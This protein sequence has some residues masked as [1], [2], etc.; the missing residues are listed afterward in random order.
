MFT[1]LR[2]QKI[3][4]VVLVTMLLLG[5]LMPGGL[6]SA[7]AADGG[8]TVSSPVYNEDGTVTVNTYSTKSEMYINGNFTDWATFKPMSLSGTTTVDG[9][10]QNVF[11]YN[12]STQD[13]NKTGGVVQYKYIPQASWS[14]DYVDFLNAGPK[15]GGNSAVHFLKLGLSQKQLQPGQSAK[16]EA[17]RYLADGNQ[18]D[19]TADV[20]WTSSQPDAVTFANGTVQVAPDAP[21]GTLTLTGV[22]QGV[23]ATTALEIVEALAVPKVK[24]VANLTDLNDRLMIGQATPEITGEVEIEDIT[25]GAGKG[26][27]L[28]A[29]LG[30]RFE[31]D[32]DYTWTQAVYKDD[33]GNS[34]RFSAQFTPDRAGKWYY[35]MRFSADNGQTWDPKLLGYKVNKFFDEQTIV[36]PY[37]VVLTWT[38]DAK[39]TQTITWKTAA[40]V[41][42]SYVQYAEKS[43]E[44]SFPGVNTT[45][46][47]EEQGFSAPQ[48]A[49]VSAKFNT[50][51]L[52]GLKPGTAYVYRVGAGTEWS[53][54]A[55]FTTEASTA[56]PF[57]FLIFGDSQSG[58]QEESD[59]AKWGETVNA[60]YLAN[61]EAKFI[62]NNGDLVE[63][64]SDEHWHKWF[65]GAEGVIENIPEM[66]VAGNHEY[67][68]T[69]G[70]NEQAVHFKQQ[71]NL[72]QNGPDRLKGLVYSYNYGDVHIAVLNSQNTEANTDQTEKMGDI[73]AEQAAWLDQ[74]LKNNDKKWTIVFY[75]KAS[76]YSRAGRAAD[77]EQVKLAFQPIIDK[78]HVDLV[79]GAHDHTI[80]RTFPIYNNNF[81][82]NTAKGTVYYITGRSGNKNYSDPFQQVWD[83]YYKND[84]EDTN[85]LSVHV[86]GD[87]LTVKAIEK[88]GNLLD[89]Y[90]ID[91]ITGTPSPA[92]PKLPITRAESLTA[93]AD[94]LTAGTA[95]GDITAEV[96]S[97]NVTNYTGRGVHIQAQL[98]YK[99]SGGDQYRWVDAVYVRDNG[100]NDVY[101]ATFTPDTA[102]NWEYVMRFSGDGGSTWTA[103]EAKTVKANA[104]N[105]GGEAPGPAVLSGLSVDQGT[106]S[107]A[108]SSSVFSYRVDVAN[109]VSGLGIF[110]DTGD[111]Q[112]VLSVTGATYVSV[113]SSVYEYRLANLVTGP[114]PLEIK[115]ANEQG[116]TNT[117]T[118]VVNRA[119]S[120][121]A[122]LSGL[123]LSNATISPAFGAGITSYSAT[124]AHGVASTNVTATASDSTATIK[125]NNA[126]V[127]NGQASGS[128]DL[129]VGS[130]EITI[131][132]KAQDGTTKNYT[133]TVNRQA[134]SGGGQPPETASPTPA[135]TASA[136]S[137][138]SPT[139]P[140]PATGATPV[141]SPADVFQTKVVNKEEVV[142]AVKE[143]LEAMNN[144]SVSFSDIS[145]HWSRNEIVA[146]VK[147]RIINGYENGTFQPEAS[148][149]RGEFAAMVSRAFGWATAQ[150]SAPFTDTATNWASGYI[151]TLA[152]KGI[153]NGY[154]D[155]SFKPGAPMS[156]AEMVSILAR[157]LN[158]G[159]LATG[160]AAAF[161]DVSSGHWAKNVIE[162]A[163]K[164]QLIQGVTSSA[165]KPDNQTTRAEAITVL[166][167]A[168]KSDSTIK[169]LI[170]GMQHKL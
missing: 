43:G 135:P 145:Q 16:V 106:I 39:T 102:G 54:T 53:D 19:L 130:N 24:S 18:A 40:D 11:S 37:D 66:P 3:T 147:L 23:S 107:P 12:L 139:P 89:E 109:S 94:E 21:L 93:L 86:N 75:H 76:Y 87:Q 153:I 44:A 8:G 70:V 5:V 10:Q 96:N 82:D 48:S 50:A 61:P 124:V 62:V 158:L 137:T 4:A 95:S 69:Y 22:Y 146:A 164:A 88:N 105:T 81:V 116:S 28:V 150:G 104:S 115:L 26:N 58:R 49:N 67:Y 90:T 46:K 97:A 144:M 157:I 60:A 29:Q 101:Q 1:R 108:F 30:Y 52:T 68:S 166:L 136:T 100:N 79:F 165:F 64:G 156:R 78:Y 121:N 13:L 71:F 74:D 154:S 32:A 118:L 168:L 125:V 119:Q 111:A 36:K 9:V 51:T 57:Q 84:T 7:Y 155:G 161:T 17:F 133:V 77:A 131:A 159:Q 83:A 114:N 20:Q 98:G 15:V 160:N 47:S 149:T 42:E 92:L 2:F 117:Y 126:A 85:Y 152:A 63:K 170:E 25:N 120:S 41:N 35:A 142:Q 38:Q 45:V 59:Y 55:T 27:N 169:E 167:R 140:P 127:V 56:E 91:K 80:T 123:T 138:A 110:L 151:G 134:V 141:P 143:S 6:K 73:L 31:T 129:N 113:T 148:V 33:V 65:E 162:E 112:P 103:T 122:N 99:L 34:D 14:G 128:I 163:Y 72:P 132:V